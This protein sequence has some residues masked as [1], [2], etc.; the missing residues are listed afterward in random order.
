MIRNLTSV[1]LVSLLFACQAP[2][3]QASA[4][5]DLSY[6]S[7]QPAL[8]AD[9]GICTSLDERDMAISPDHSEIIFTRGSY[10][11][12]ARVLVSAKNGTMS[13]LPFSGTHKD[14]EPFFSPDGSR[15]Y[16]VSDRPIYGDS[17]RKDYNIWYVNRTD[18]AWSKPVALD[19]TINTRKDEFYPSLTRDG[20]LYFT[21]I[22][23]GGVG[24]EDIWVSEP[25]GE[26]FGTP[27]VLDTAINGPGYEFNA[28]VSP[29]DN[30]LIFSSYGR[31]DGLGGGDLYVSHRGEE[32]NWTP[33]RNLG[34]TINSPK[35][36]YCPFLDETHAVFYFSSNRKPPHKDRIE[37]VEELAS[38]SSQSLNGLGNIY[39]CASSVLNP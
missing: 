13:V 28:W 14:I 36:D 16:F 32:G 31:P 15:L 26:G 24:S 22:Y 30:M 11:Q 4:P 20:K 1:L 2:A 17:T 3:E 37:T 18:G 9:G 35:L 10:D 39:H 27:A 21:A 23:P 34:P 5:I 7:T 29:E 33:A 8:F 12:Q 38:I 6:S 25:A 19:S